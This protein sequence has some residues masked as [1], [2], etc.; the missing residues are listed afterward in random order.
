[1][2]K[3]ATSW[4][5]S[6]FDRT[7]VFPGIKS[8]EID[9]HMRV[10]VGTRIE[11]VDQDRGTGRPAGPRPA[12]RPGNRHP[13]ELRPAEQRHQPRLFRHRHGR[14]P[15]LRYRDHAAQSGLSRRTLSPDTARRAD[16]AVPRH[17]LQLPAGRHHREDSELWPAVA[18][19][20]RDQRT[21][22]RYEFHLRNQNAGPTAAVSPALPMSASSRSWASQPCCWRPD[23]ASRWAPA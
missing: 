6:L 5:Y 3:T 14:Q 1:M 2:T 17:R 15:G 13:D 8:G 21:R 12:A 23:A 18:N 7:A 11:E 10:P 16:G 9:M 20:R 4:N 19:R 22:S